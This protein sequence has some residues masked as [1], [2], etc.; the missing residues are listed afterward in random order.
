MENIV[1]I[2]SGFVGCDFEFASGD[3]AIT[4]SEREYFAVDKD[5]RFRKIDFN[6]IERCQQRKQQQY[7]YLFAHDVSKKNL[8]RFIV[9]FIIRKKTQ[10]VA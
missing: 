10:K 5:R 7:P 2:E 9:L 3:N 6:G 8:H 1:S 4:Y